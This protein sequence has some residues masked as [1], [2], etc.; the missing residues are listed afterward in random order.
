MDSYNRGYAAGLG[1]PGD[2]IG[3]AKYVSNST[4][5]LGLDVTKAAGFFA[6][7][8]TISGSGT[9]L[10]GKTVISYRGTDNF[11]DSPVLGG[12]DILNGWVS[13]TGVLTSQV[14]LAR[15][16]YEK[17]TG[18]SIFDGPAAGYFITGHSLGGGLAQI[19]SLVSG[20]QGFGFDHMPGG[21][22]A[23]AIA[24]Q[25]AQ[26]ALYL[27]AFKSISVKDEILQSVRNGSIQ[28]ILAALGSS[29]IQG[30]VLIDLLAT[31]LGIPVN[32]S[33]PAKT[34][35]DIAARTAAYEAILSDPSPLNSYSGIWSPISR[36]TKLHMQDLLVLLQFAADGATAS[37]GGH[38]TNWHDAGAQLWTAYFD[39]AV[40]KAAGADK[41]DGVG[42][43]T[44]KLGRM[45]AYSAVDKAGPDSGKPFGDTGAWSFFDDA[46]DLGAALKGTHA[47]FFDKTVQFG[48][49]NSLDVKQ[50][51]ANLVVEYAGALAKNRIIEGATPP[52]G[53]PDVRKG[54]LS[55]SDGSDGSNAVLS[56][57]VSS[58]MWKDALHLQT[59]LDPIGLADFRAAFLG[60]AP[61]T[62]GIVNHKFLNWLLGSNKIDDASLKYL[63]KLG[64]SATTADIFDRFDIA[65]SDQGGTVKIA[66][67]PYD[68]GE[69]RGNNAHVDVYIGN[70]NNENITGTKG[71]DLIFGG[72][73]TDRIDGG[74]GDDVIVAGVG[75]KSVTIGGT[76]RDVVIN[77]S[78]GGVVYGDTVDGV[79]DAGQ[80]DAF[81][82]RRYRRQRRYLLVRARCH[83]HGRP[84]ARSAAVPGHCADGR[85]PQSGVFRIGGRGAFLRRRFY[86]RHR[87]KCDHRP[88]R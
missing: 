56:V 34:L 44:A 76:G 35:S 30:T 54:I 16:F 4:D 52:V 60:Q 23:E 29:S 55:L 13:G 86:P 37:G 48:I 83:D 87:H 57:D 51:V 75:S 20:T 2:Q 70:A 47:A 71:D 26:T 53:P 36:A 88:V 64:W 67:R 42:S 77:F 46:D 59:K 31:Y 7:S 9:D 32:L 73:G 19:I 66:D 28:L 27:N 38:F 72:S 25:G 39:D 69:L 12:G 6:A 80:L 1:V 41:M 84:G 33:D 11:A 17:V 58:V 18:R 81:A 3:P 65:T 78:K 10:D 43:P 50:E 79:D 82:C 85:Q 74:A 61:V 63:A 14:G 62:D 40:A 21:L 15:Q 5:L 45:I 24:A 8:Y 68:P 22:A 49:F